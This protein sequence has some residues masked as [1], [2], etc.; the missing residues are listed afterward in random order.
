MVKR[1]PQHC[2]LSSTVA[3]GKGSGEH[4]LS[5]EFQ[6]A[7]QTEASV[8]MAASTLKGEYRDGPLHA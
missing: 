7:S 1:L 3:S 8:A 2:L 6:C 5:A 4:F